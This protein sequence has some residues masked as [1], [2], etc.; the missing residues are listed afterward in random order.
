M[1][2]SRSAFLAGGGAVAVVGAGAA[3][4]DT[5]WHPRADGS[6]SRGLIID[7]FLPMLADR[8][9]YVRR[10]GLLGWS[11]G[12]YGALLMATELPDPGPVCAV[13]AALWP[14]YGETA[15]GSFDSQADFDEWNMFDR[16]DRLEGLQVRVDCGRGDP[17]FRN[18]ADFCDDTDIEFHA[19]AGAHDEGYWRRVLTDELAWLGDRLA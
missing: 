19:D 4:G 10:P 13:S 11:M 17:F 7:R 16:R 3:G 9:Y 6:D 14:S 1:R 15:P 2:V 18:V 12:G 5:Y 8:G